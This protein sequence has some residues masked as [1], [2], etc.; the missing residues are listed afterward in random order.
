[1]AH[2]VF[3]SGGFRPA[4]FMIAVRFMTTVRWPKSYK[5]VIP[6]IDFINGSD[7]EY[8]NLRGTS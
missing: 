2:F 6:I 1:V 7:E 5:K 8:Q 3:G 4:S